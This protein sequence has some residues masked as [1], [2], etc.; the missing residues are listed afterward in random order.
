MLRLEIASCRT[1]DPHYCKCSLVSL[2]L[3]FV[4]TAVVSCEWYKLNLKSSSLKRKYGNLQV[5]VLKAIMGTI[6]LII[7]Y[8]GFLRFSSIY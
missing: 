1:E 2:V 5:L 4:A 6:D 8:L 3:Y 7:G